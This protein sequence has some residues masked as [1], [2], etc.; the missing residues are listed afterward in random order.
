MEPEI[1]INRIESPDGRRDYVCLLPPKNGLIAASIIGMF[2]AP[3]SGPPVISQET[4]SRNGVFVDLMHTVIK[5]EAPILSAYLAQAA[6]VRSGPV[7]VIDRRAAEDTTI[8]PEDT[9]G[10]F[11]ARNNQIIPESYEP[12]PTHRLLSDRGFFQLQEELHTALMRELAVP[13]FHKKWRSHLQM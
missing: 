5:R 6:R 8:Q 9:F 3:E 11:E 12:N 1:Y 7:Y 2:R 4:F 10:A 13:A